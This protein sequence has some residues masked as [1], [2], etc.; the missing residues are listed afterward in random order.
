MSEQIN[1]FYSIFLK[2]GQLQLLRDLKTCAEW[3][4]A[5]VGKFN[6][7]P[8]EGGFAASHSC[9]RTLWNSPF[10]PP[11]LWAGWVAV[12]SPHRRLTSAVEHVSGRNC[13]NSG[14]V[15]L[16][17]KG[18]EVDMEPSYGAGHRHRHRCHF[19]CLSGRKYILNVTEEEIGC[20]HKPLFP[21]RYLRD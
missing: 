4:L 18:N 11:L 20:H 10:R 7:G 17:C 8:F 12:R 1:I 2:D 15:R 5:L 6:P 21:V 19:S 9:R 16:I 13:E 14:N 3:L